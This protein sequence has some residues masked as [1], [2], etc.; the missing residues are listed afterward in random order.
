MKSPESRKTMLL[1]HLDAVFYGEAWHGAALLP[2]LRAINIEIAPRE[3]AEGFSPWKIALHCAYWKFVVRKALSPE[4]ETAPFP[5]TPKDF[6]GLPAER[7]PAAWEAD[8]RFLEEEHRQLH[9]AVERFPADRLDAL[10]PDDPL[11]YAGLILGAA[12]HDVY[13]TAHIRNLGVQSF[14]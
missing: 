2:S 13:H 4:S 5:R 1:D 3:N 8:I 10:R 9:A 6:P 14:P 11:T 7:T 12:S